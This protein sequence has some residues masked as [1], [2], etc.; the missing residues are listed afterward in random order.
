MHITVKDVNTYEG[1]D[2]WKSD[3]TMEEAKHADHEENLSNLTF[4][5]LFLTF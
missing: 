4:L 5:S 1:K 2:D 3:K